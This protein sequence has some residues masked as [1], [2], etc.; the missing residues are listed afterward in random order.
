MRKDYAV[1]YFYI[2]GQLTLFAAFNMYISKQILNMRRKINSCL[3]FYILL[4]S[5]VCSIK[6]ICK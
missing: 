4:T 6:Y 1:T 3:P 5:L 2:H